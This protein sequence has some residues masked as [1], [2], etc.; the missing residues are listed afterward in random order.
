MSDPLAPAAPRIGVR[1]GPSVAF[2]R[3]RVSEAEKT[4]E[5]TSKRR[6][7]YREEGRIATSRDIGGVAIGLGCLLVFVL[8]GHSLTVRVTA[9]FAEI[10][11]AVAAV[12]DTNAPG[13]LRTVLLRAGRAVFDL[14]AAI[15]LVA[16]TM[17]VLAGLAQTGANWA[18]KALTPKFSRL[19]P[20]QGLKN[21]MFSAHALTQLGLSIAKTVVLGVAVYLVL[22]GYMPQFLALAQ[23]ELGR[24][25]AFIGHVLVLLFVTTLL[26]SAV[27]AAVE[28]AITRHRMHE[29]MKMSKQEV[30][31]EHKQQD[32][33]PEVKARMR[34]Q[35][36]RIGRNQMLAA[37]RK[38]DVVVV[39]PTHFAVALEYKF[40]QAGAP[41]LL[42]KGQDELAARIREQARK[43]QIPIIANP[44]VA[45]AI[46][47]GA[48]VGQDVPPELYEMVAK[49]IAY[50]YKLRNA[51]LSA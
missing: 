42:A 51:R 34:A 11:E 22:R 30:K 35:M 10:A 40:G 24:A 15:L 47:A 20:L 33:D 19:N 45:R 8:E 3:A 50:L 44:P 46:Y 1:L 43:H 48:R 21:A 7:E 31:D 41:K 13:L 49:V 6:Q 27:L 17:G 29:Q 16:T 28:Y 2:G 39:N 38:A 14:S 37:T 32:G 25:M 23:V 4:E 5:P 9:L 26:A 36:R 12:P 18:S